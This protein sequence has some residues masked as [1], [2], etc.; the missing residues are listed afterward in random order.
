[1]VPRQFFL[2]S[3]QILMSIFCLISLCDENERGV[4]LTT[5]YC[6]VI[7]NKYLF[8]L[9]WELMEMVHLCIYHKKLESMG[10]PTSELK[11]VPKDLPLPFFPSFGILFNWMFLLIKRYLKDTNAVHTITGLKI[12]EA[13]YWHQLIWIF[14]EFFP[15]HW[16]L[17]KVWLYLENVRF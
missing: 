10:L 14:A 5:A 4:L 16:K 17:V 12:S 3:Y 7:F 9:N 11:G 2:S 1:M 15:S 8:K 6:A 13:E